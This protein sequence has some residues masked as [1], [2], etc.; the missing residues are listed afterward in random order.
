MNG[1]VPLEVAALVPLVPL[2]WLVPEA[3]VVELGVVVVVVPW[4]EDDGAG[5]VDAGALED[6]ALD[7]EVVCDGVPCEDP[8]VVE[9]GVVLPASG[10]MYCWLP[11]D[12]ANATPGRASSTAARTARV[13]SA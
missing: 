12:C 7:G 6:G 11:A 9:L 3:E 4:L 8:V 13:H 2:G 10:S 1:S 5:P